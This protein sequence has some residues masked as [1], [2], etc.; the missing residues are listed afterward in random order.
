MG[1]AAVVLLSGGMDSVASL[2]W[3]QARYPRMFAL[4]FMYGQPNADQELAA[5]GYA[6]KVA[7]VDWRRLA[8]S[9]A[10]RGANRL[11][12][13]SPVVPG[14]NLVFLSIA[15]AHAAA[16]WG[17][18]RLDVVIGSNAEDA[19]DFPDCRQ[20][21]VSAMS[22]ALSAGHGRDV[23]VMAP[24]LGKTKAQILYAV[25]PDAAALDAVRRSW[26]CY[27]ATGPCGECGACVK[28]AAAFRSQGIADAA[29]P[30]V[31]GGGDRS[32]ER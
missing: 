15:A 9:D 28:R 25:K 11:T 12:S 30:I 31:M 4:S 14:R 23:V 26:S 10:V 17:I 24:W 22:A 18:G 19:A 32:R 16:E 8:V 3:A 13:T 21:T 20:E 2:F 6:A 29:E 7:G 5:A 27:R 1:H